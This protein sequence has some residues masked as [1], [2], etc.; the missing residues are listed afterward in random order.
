MSRLVLGSLVG[1]IADDVAAVAPDGAR[2]LEVG[3]GPGY[4]SIRLARQHG[5]EVIGLD[6]DPAMI[7]RARANA[8]RPGGGHQSRPSFLVGD[9]SSLA[10]PDRSI[11]LV[12]STLPMRFCGGGA[13]GI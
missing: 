4:L 6:L 1:Q 2:E 7:S 9:V 12:V 8:D 5:L 11:D 3:C 13:E 10:F